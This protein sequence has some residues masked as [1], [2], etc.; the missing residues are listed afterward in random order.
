[1]I[2]YKMLWERGKAA[3]KIQQAVFTRVNSSLSPVTPCDSDVHDLI[4]KCRKQTFF[5]F[6][7]NAEGFVFL[8]CSLGLL[9]HGLGSS[10]AHSFHSVKV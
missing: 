5:P 7:L 2:E 8:A 9:D 4:V 6:L 3:A 10:L 1:M